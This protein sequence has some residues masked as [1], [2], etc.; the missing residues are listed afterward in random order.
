MNEEQYRALCAECDRLL[1][2]PDSTLERIAIP[3]LHVVREHPV[4]L[5]SYAALYESGSGIG[6]VARRWLR[7]LRS[8]VDRLRLFVRAVRSKGREWH[9]PAALPRSA[10]VVFV[11]H[12]LN[13][14]QAGQET[15]FYF[16]DAP[17]AIAA[18][19]RPLIA[20][21]NHTGERG[22]ALVRQ[23]KADAVPRVIL[24][25]TLRLKDEI[26]LRARLKKEAT[27]LKA[28]ARKEAPGRARRIV[29]RASEEALSPGSLA[30]MRLFVQ[31]RALVARF[32]PKAIVLT[33]E[34]HAWERVAFAAARSVRP[35]VRCIGYQHAALF[36]LQHAIRRPLAAQY[37]PDE[38]LTA[39]AVGKAQ[40]EG[41]PALRGVPVDVVGS[42]R[43]LQAN[44]KL[45]GAQGT[46][47]LACL[48]LPEGIPGEC[49][50]LFEFSLACARR[51]PEIQFIWRLHPI[52]SYSSLARRNRVLRSLPNNVRLSRA[53]LDADA[54]ICRWALYRGTTAIVQAASAGVRPVYLA[55]PDEMTVDPLY[56]LQN[57]RVT[58]RS[59]P[60][61]EDLLRADV[62]APAP[63]AD[64]AKRTAEAY[65][66][67]FFVPFDYRAMI[68]AIG[69]NAG[70]NGSKIPKRTGH[71]HES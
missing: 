54:A 18:N 60:E 63:A 3:W 41:S 7:F 47:E 28:L 59:I 46:R 35:D 55:L 34:G 51:C 33:H 12:L 65:C 21:I 70:I 67:D 53:P 68:A 49:N 48:V 38:I 24:S 13:P 1:Q 11:S 31:V 66:D 27:R 39:G 16:G 62:R 20:L 43:G 45:R 25:R 57:W 44:S 40:L 17:A 29:A 5:E 36:R 26:S 4:F 58:V 50:L 69:R 52:L 2:A 64:P 30:A 32:Q 22:A 14:A 56:E 9:G 10:D 23:W 15:D 71:R 37:N 6:G 19:H 8:R 61:F 42:I